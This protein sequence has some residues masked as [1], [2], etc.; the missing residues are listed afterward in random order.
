MNFVLEYSIFFLFFFRFVPFTD[1]GDEDNYDSYQGAVVFLTSVY[2]YVML[3]VVYSKSH[4]YRKSLFSNRYLSLSLIVCTGISFIITVY[5]PHFVAEW[6]ELKMPP[7]V[8]YRFLIVFLAAFNF[9]LSGLVEK[10]I[11]DWFI[12]KV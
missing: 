12:D 4:P 5:P 11:I 10:L 8:K 9:L 6:L 1:P 3:A 2:Q 7:Y